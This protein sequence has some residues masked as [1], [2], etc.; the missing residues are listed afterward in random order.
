[1]K[2]RKIIASIIGIGI[3]FS[4][5]ACEKKK[6]EET[7][8][9]TT[10]VT[11][12]E[13]T[14]ETTEEST[15]EETEEEYE[16]ELIR[17]D[18]DEPLLGFEGCYAEGECMYADFYD[19][20]I[21]NADGEFL[22]SQFGY[23]CDTP[24][25]Y[26]QDWDGDGNDELICPVQYG[27]DMALCVNVYRNNNGTIE[28]GELDER[29]ISN[30]IGE[31]LCVQ[32]HS[33]V[34]DPENKLVV[35]GYY[36]G[37][38]NETF[39]LKMDDYVFREAGSEVSCDPDFEGWKTEKVV[40]S[41]EPL[42]GFE[43]WYCERT[44]DGYGFS[45][46]DFYTE[47]G[48]LFARQFGEACEEK[49]II[50]IQDLDGD[51]KDELICDCYYRESGERHY[52]IYKNDNGVIKG[53]YLTIEKVCNIVGSQGISEWDYYEDYDKTDNRIVIYFFG[54]ERFYEPL[55]DDFTFVDGDPTTKFGS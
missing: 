47:D 13:T 46:W 38:N 49:P 5:C 40:L 45:Y 54:E 30:R 41:D 52:F 23:E 4:I 34:Y 11:T 43:N 37:L 32:N 20:T 25:Y 33:V 10:S 1:M 48:S 31:M 3:M 22:G 18:I 29:A 36:D 26:L 53:G 27:A 51:G 24:V 28:E 9:E 17:I 39:P 55:I 6:V 50:Y 16:P 7:T 8:E 15:S 35:F 19:W 44:Y 12:Q 2:M 21:Y 42:L 14:S